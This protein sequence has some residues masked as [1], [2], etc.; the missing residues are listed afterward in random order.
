VKFVRAQVVRYTGLVGL[1]IVGYWAIVFVATFQ[2]LGAPVR[3]RTLGWLGPPPRDQ[4]CLID[5]GKVWE[6]TCPEI[7][8]FQRHRLG[9]LVWLRLNG[10]KAG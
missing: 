9:C 8:P 2:L 6:W 5:I 1:A 7:T 3:D 10:L 4:R